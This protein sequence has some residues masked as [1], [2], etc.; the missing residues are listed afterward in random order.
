MKSPAKI[1]TVALIVRFDGKSP[2]LLDSLT[3]DTEIHRLESAVESGESDPLQAVYAMRAQQA[4]EDEEFGNYVEDLLSQPFVRPEIREHG[5]QW[6]KSKL[7]IEEFQ[8]SEREASSVIAQYA[9]KV[10][11]ESPWRRDFFLAAPAA[12]VRIRIFAMEESDQSSKK[13]RVA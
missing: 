3:D 11:E 5:V 8:R 12:K 9:F 4:K 2:R 13:S 7:R 1:G 6:L 10:F